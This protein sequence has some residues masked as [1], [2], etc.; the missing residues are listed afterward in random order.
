[1]N[2]EKE[3]ARCPSCGYPVNVFLGKDASC[4]G[5]FL[6]CKNRNCKKV[7]ELRL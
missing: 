4:R 7:F 6:K 3:K 1:M 5:V 2:R